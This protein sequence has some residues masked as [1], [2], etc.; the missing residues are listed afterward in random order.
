MENLIIGEDINNKPIKL[1]DL[2]KRQDG[3]VGRFEVRDF[4]LIFRY[5]KEREDGAI[6][7]YINCGNRYELLDI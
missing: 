6:C 7:S 4:E 1:G 5:E 2:V 3:V